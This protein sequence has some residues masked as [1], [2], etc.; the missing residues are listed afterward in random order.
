MECLSLPQSEL[1]LGRVEVLQWDRLYGWVVTDDLHGMQPTK[2]FLVSHVHSLT[3]AVYYQ[4]K[5]ILVW[6]LAK[7]I[8]TQGCGT[9]S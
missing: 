2:Y 7:V 8:P 4:A 1:I 5:G 6:L 3:P 9:G